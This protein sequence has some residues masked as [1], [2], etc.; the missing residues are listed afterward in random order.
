MTAADRAGGADRSADERADGAGSSPG[1]IGQSPEAG[2]GTGADESAETRAG[3][4][5]ETG[6]VA[7]GRRL[8]AA[9]AFATR[10]GRA[11]VGDRRGAALCCGVL[12]VYGLCWRLGF[13][14]NDNY[15]LANAFLAVSEGRLAVE[16]AV[17]GPGLGT[18]GTFRLDGAT[19][20]R[21]YG[22]LVLSLPF[23]R[24]V[25]AAAAVA[26]L[27][28]AL[29]S[30]WGLAVVG[31]TVLIADPLGRR[32]QPPGGIDGTAAV[33]A[34]GCGL[35]L[36]GVALAVRGAPPIAARWHGLIAL[37]L[38][39]MVAAALVGVFGYRLLTRIHGPRLGLAAGVATALS[40]PIGFWAAFPKR[41]V[42]IAL[43]VLLS[44]YALHRSRA[45]A[46]TR[47]RAGSRS[48]RIRHAT[49]FRALAYVPVGVVAWI[50]AL[51]GL[52]L[53]AA[54]C[55]VDLPTGERNGRS[56]AA[57]GAALAGSLPP[58]FVTN[59]L[60]AGDPLQPPR[61]FVRW[62]AGG[63]AGTAAVFPT[64]WPR[65]AI[66]DGGP[67]VETAGP[68]GAPEAAGA[69]GAA[70]ALGDVLSVALGFLRRGVGTLV[71]DPGQAYA[72]LVR[73]DYAYDV[74]QVGGTEVIRL[75]V[76]ESA[77]LAGA[78]VSLPVLG[79]VAAR[80]GRLGAA[81]RRAAGRRLRL[82]PA[83]TVDLFA[84]AY[85]LL[86]LAANL[87]RLTDGTQV[88]GRHVLP[89]FPLLVYGVARLPAVRRVLRDRAG[90]AAGAYV[91]GVCVGGQLLVLAVWATG[92]SLGEAS[93]LHA[94]VNAAAA[95]P[96]AGWALADAAGLRS[97]GTDRAGAVALGLAAAA[98]TAFFLVARLRHFD[99][100]GGLVLPIV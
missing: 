28:V 22:Q 91:A 62:G 37:Q 89:V 12:V 46:G 21:N 93:G 84:V 14:I 16:R 74:A 15:T 92:A 36:V 72:V 100:V 18:P 53:L 38:A 99:Y 11:V 49:A 82:S 97:D 75:S 54:L 76:L 23:L 86:A 98:G 87:H 19:Y 27:R 39:T 9:G 25:E 41:H 50:H 51:E 10:V 20:G 68:S 61:A 83:R 3:T 71:D 81:A 32:L 94:A 44:A 43:C 6:A 95:V 88:T 56:L 63:L 31:F 79:V 34:A 67:T 85:V 33:T 55:A 69:W 26:Q 7:D 77:P 65:T 4:E 64:D 29:A 52:L 35:A 42:P 40:A 70:G 57:A 73:S 5:G 45:A 17:Y 58:M 24:A 78:L 8:D 96:V 30:A 2:G 60:I 59:H 48:G 90:L 13:L 47:V 1:A 66:P 80:D